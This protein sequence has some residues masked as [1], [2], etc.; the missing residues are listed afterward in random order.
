MLVFEKDMFLGSDP[1]WQNLYAK[2]LAWCSSGITG[3]TSSGIAPRTE[4]KN[5]LLL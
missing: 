4:K 5:L 2:G 3:L 1:H